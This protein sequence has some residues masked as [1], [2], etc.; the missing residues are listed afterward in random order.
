MSSQLASHVQYAREQKHAGKARK[1]K[2]AGDR[3]RLFL[4]VMLTCLAC[5]L[6]D[7]TAT[8][9]V[10]AFQDAQPATPS[11]SSTENSLG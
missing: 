11:V 5:L 7:C 4:L 9:P 8:R 3:R 1:K 2:I 6:L 10:P